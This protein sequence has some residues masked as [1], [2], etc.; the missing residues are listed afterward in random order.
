[1]DSAD[2]SEVMLVVV[3][4]A[5]QKLTYSKHS[6]GMMPTQML[7]IPVDPVN[8]GNLTVKLRDIEMVTAE[9]FFASYR[10]TVSGGENPVY[11]YGVL[12]GVWDVEESEW[13]VTNESPVTVQKTLTSAMSESDAYDLEYVPATGM[14]YAV[15]SAP[16]GLHRLIDV[17]TSNWTDI[18]LPATD[19]WTSSGRSIFEISA[20][21]DGSVL[22]LGSSR[23]TLEN[24]YRGYLLKVDNAD[25][26]V[27]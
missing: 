17:A 6:S 23:G 13:V 1:M 18:Q 14:L 4:T 26:L 2:G 22:Y 7:P 8:P 27:V 12:R 24:D 11:I 9:L 10:L 25:Q 15:T 3:D 20:S 21:M 19:A 16:P 5:S